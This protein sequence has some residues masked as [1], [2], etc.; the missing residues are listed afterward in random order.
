MTIVKEVFVLL[1]RMG[2]LDVILPFILV[3]AIVWSVLQKTKVL[4]KK[5]QHYNAIVAFILG[6]FVVAA[7]QIVDILQHIVQWSALA[8]IGVFFVTVIGKFIGGIPD[9]AKDSY[10]KY[11][12]LVVM[13]LI[14][15]YALGLD[16]WLN[17]NF[18]EG[19]ILPILFSLAIVIGVLWFVLR[20]EKG[21][22]VGAAKPER[23]KKAK[24]VKVIEDKDK[25]GRIKF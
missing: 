17:F 24:Q 22:E 4:G 5:S 9:P 13:A 3:Y 21:V 7:L 1:E 16:G 10:P 23:K 20:P 12:A 8:V 15:F 14:A 19:W 25:P 2:L 6:F 11:I 18:V